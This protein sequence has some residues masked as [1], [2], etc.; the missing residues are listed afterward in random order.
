MD[1]RGFANPGCR[2]LAR[3]RAIDLHDWSL[4]GGTILIASCASAA[5]VA[6][7]YWRFFLAR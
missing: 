3:P 1:G 4:V 5:A 2:T 7:G 6:V